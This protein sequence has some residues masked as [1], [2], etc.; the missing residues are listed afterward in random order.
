MGV[1]FDRYRS[2]SFKICKTSGQRKVSRDITS[3]NLTISR[4]FLAAV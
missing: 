3:V 4:L 2:P 1:H